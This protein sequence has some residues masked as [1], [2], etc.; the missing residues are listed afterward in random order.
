MCQVSSGDPF[1]DQVCPTGRHM[2]SSSNQTECSPGFYW[3][4]LTLS[5]AVL[6]SCSHGA[7]FH[8][9]GEDMEIEAVHNSLQVAR[10]AVS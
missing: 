9:G 4:M 5:R 10:G 3:P 6:P 1:S 2:L 8:A 7:D